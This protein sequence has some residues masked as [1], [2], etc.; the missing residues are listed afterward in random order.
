MPSERAWA[1]SDFFVSRVHDNIFVT[2]CE[3]FQ[4][5]IQTGIENTILIK[6]NQ[7]GT[8]TETFRLLNSKIYAKW[9]EMQFVNRLTE[10]FAMPAKASVSNHITSWFPR[11]ACP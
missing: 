6:L 4:K 7:V 2:N 5:S 11:I 1:K 8:L 9:K 10:L 3:I